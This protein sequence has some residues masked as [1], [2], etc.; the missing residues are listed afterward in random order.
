MDLDPEQTSITSQL[1]LI[2]ILTLINAFFAS[3]E[4][5][6]V[7]LNKNK[8]KL[9]EEEGNKKAKLLLKLME[10]PTNFLSTVQVGITL[11]GFFSSASAAT[12]LSKDVALYLKGLNV[13]YSGQVALA[14]VTIVLSYITLV[15][16]ELFPKRI[17]LK[18][19]K[20]LQ[21]SV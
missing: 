21:C 11:A 17:A 5:S 12:G 1:I 8:I 13:P 2:V 9:L 6:I 7:S 16:G 20:L 14:L 19:Q 15:F 3:A 10:E 4:M 18:N